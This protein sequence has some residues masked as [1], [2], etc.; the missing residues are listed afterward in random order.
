MIIIANG[1][2]DN[3]DYQPDGRW[4]TGIYTLQ[5]FVGTADLTGVVTQKIAHA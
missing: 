1:D 5:V 3:P 2:D 4:L